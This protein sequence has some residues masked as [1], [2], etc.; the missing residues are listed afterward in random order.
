MADSEDLKNILLRINGKG[1]KAYK[2][3]KNVYRFRDF[4][5]FI[6]HV[7]GDPFALPSR[8][9]VRVDANNALFP[10]D[11]FNSKSR[12]IALRD[13]LSR[14]FHRA[15][16]QFSRE[17]RGSG[18]SGAII[19][20]R[21]GQEIL[22][23]TSVFISN[24]FVEA[25]FLMGLPAFGRK[26]A[27]RDAEEMFFSELPQIVSASLFF[28]NLDSQKLYS[29][30]ETAE[31]ADFLRINLNNRGCAAFV[32][33]NSVLPRKSGIDDRPLS[34]GTIVPFSSPDSLRISVDLPNRGPISGM[35]IKNGITLIV[36]GGYHGKS[37]LLNALE[38]GIYNHIPGDGREF[39]VTN[40]DAVK[41]RAEDGRRIEKTSIS[42]FINNLPFNRDTNAFC[43]D[44]A[45]GSTS[46][47]ANIIEALE[48]GAE[49]LLIDEDTSATNFMIRDHRMQ[50][51]VSKDKEPITPFIDKVRLL[52]N[53]RNISTILVIGGSG[54]YFDIADS[55]ICMVEYKP[56]VV[57][58]QARAIAEKYRAERS[59]EGGDRF[60]DI[61]E[62]A[63]LASSFDA[64]KGKRDVKISPKGLHSIMFG[65]ST[66]D[67]G[68]IEQL[69]DTSQTKAIGDALYY[70]TRYM[71]GVRSLKE[72]LDL[73]SNDI[74]L[75]GLD[76]LSPWPVGDYAAFRK[77][78]LAAALNRLRTLKVNA[79][80][81]APS[82]PLIK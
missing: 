66:I 63:P 68:A 64:S 33:D 42:P 5:L 34:S 35:G 23:R 2:D 17:R 32:A 56:L 72:I 76:V 40:P 24:E 49:V 10:A 53:D 20:D 19:I 67:L 75:N 25:R 18:K 69:V 51:L 70:A 52:Y 8:I 13:F 77:L 39:V 47:S 59:A 62:R 58:D 4:T 71:D 81:P 57:T 9:R 73:V 38:L 3:I 79:L 22:E 60:G 44:D 82:L 11:S 30:I 6:D 36:G 55:I 15:V 43:S 7:Q 45:S 28:K 29:H 74:T 61:I 65:S 16:K 46:Q 1:Y 80:T 26:I 41:I 12:E 14:E 31:D 37:T 78:E 54:D 48:A 50:E 21:P 27:G